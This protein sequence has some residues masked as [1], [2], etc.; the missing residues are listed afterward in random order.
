MLF[1]VPMFMRTRRNTVLVVQVIHREASI[2]ALVIE[3]EAEAGGNH[4]RVGIG[5]GD[6]SLRVIDLFF[7]VA[8]SPS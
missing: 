1:F 2:T 4:I 7:A 3:V 5:I 6:F 8:H